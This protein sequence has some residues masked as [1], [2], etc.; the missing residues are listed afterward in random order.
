MLA[1]IR[2]RSIKKAGSNAAGHFSSDHPQKVI[3]SLAA[4]PGE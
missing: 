4:M 3:T 2:E 1:F